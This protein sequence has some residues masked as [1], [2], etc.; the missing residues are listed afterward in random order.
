VLLGRRRA[1]ARGC[2]QVLLTD[3][4]TLTSLTYILN[5]EQDTLTRE[6]AGC[7][8][9]DCS[10]STTFAVQLIEHSILDVIVLV[11]QQSLPQQR[12]DDARMVELCL[13]ICANLCSV[14]QA[15]QKATATPGLV[16]LVVDQALLSQDAPV[17]VECTR[18]LAA[19]LACSVSALF[20]KAS[21]CLADALSIAAP[22]FCSGA[23]VMSYPPAAAAAA[24]AAAAD[25][26]PAR[27]PVH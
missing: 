8:L 14:E 10:A 26:A 19:A 7:L 18:L 6:Q 23:C 20:W 16:D 3:S 21:G 11:L 4:L 24:A 25:R 1:G 27:I 9:W 22:N 12:Q 15:A 2:K 13:G 5:A 17:L